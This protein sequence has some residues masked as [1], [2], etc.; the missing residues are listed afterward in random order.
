MGEICIKII[1]MIFFFFLLFM[2]LNDIF[3]ILE[4]YIWVF[5]CGRVQNIRGE[6]RSIDVYGKGVIKDKGEGENW[7][8]YNNSF[9]NSLEVIVDYVKKG[10]VGF[11]V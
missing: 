10:K 3:V 7:M 4:N 5:V 9:G 1:I 6:R 2:V 11:K 8:I